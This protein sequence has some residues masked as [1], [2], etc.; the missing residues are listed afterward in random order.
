MRRKSNTISNAAH[1]SNSSAADFYGKLFG[2]LVHNSLTSS[3]LL[4]FS[5][6]FNAEKE[7]GK[8][9]VILEINGFSFVKLFFYI[10]W[11]EFSPMKTREQQF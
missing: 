8:Y 4:F 6:S 3:W 9:Q 5:L 2:C 1:G 10:F 7:A 11:K